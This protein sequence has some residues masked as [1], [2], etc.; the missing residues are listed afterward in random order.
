MICDET[1]TKKFCIN[2]SDI[3]KFDDD[4]ALKD[5]QI[6]SSIVAGSKVLIEQLKKETKT[7]N[8]CSHANLS[9]QIFFRF[10][11]RTPWIMIDKKEWCKNIPI[12]VDSGSINN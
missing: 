4:A 8:I 9:R 10:F 6:S 5:S 11:P 3:I 12:R 2:F 1:C 7:S